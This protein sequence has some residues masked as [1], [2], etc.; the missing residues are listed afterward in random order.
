MKGPPRYT[1]AAEMSVSR[2]VSPVLT[3][4]FDAGS[5]AVDRLDRLRGDPV[6]GTV[7][8]YRVTLVYLAVLRLFGWLRTP[9][10][11]ILGVVWSCSLVGSSAL[12]VCVARLKPWEVGGG[13]WERIEPLLPVVERRWWSA[14][15]GI[16]VVNGWMTAK[17]CAGSCSCSRPRSRG[18]SC[19]RS[20]GSARV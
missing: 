6:C 1:K 8:V 12:G 10:G 3:C 16:Q 5:R 4:R 13:V 14:G 15:S 20:W 2:I 9:N 19:P 11:V 18:S 7:G 17:R